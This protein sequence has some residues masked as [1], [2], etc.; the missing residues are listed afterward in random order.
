VYTDVTLRYAPTAVTD[1]T[2]T[3]AEVEPAKNAVPSAPTIE[4]MCE[5][6]LLIAETVPLKF[7][8]ATVTLPL[9]GVEKMA[10]PAP[11]TTTRPPVTEDAIIETLDRTT[12]GFVRPWPDCIAMPTAPTAALGVSIAPDMMV[13]PVAATLGSSIATDS[14]ESPTPATAAA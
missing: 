3:V 9:V 11:P 4:S 10:M 2:G 7:Q 12:D 8:A 1:T 5:R 13:K 6:E 14:V